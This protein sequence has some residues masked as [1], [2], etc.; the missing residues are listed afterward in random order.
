[1]EYD[2]CRVILASAVGTDWARHRL[3]EF[4]DQQGIAHESHSAR[5][6]SVLSEQG[7]HNLKTGQLVDASKSI[8]DPVRQLAAPIFCP[9]SRFAHP[10]RWEEARAFC[11]EV[12]YAVLERISSSAGWTEERRQGSSL[13]Y[14]GMQGRLVFSHNVPRSTLTL[15]WAM[16]DYRGRSWIPL[17]PVRD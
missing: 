12:G 2:T 8:I 11:A 6:I 15:L 13:A 17:F 9:W 4:F 3:H 7:R 16:G 5:E 1:V 14:S 10:E